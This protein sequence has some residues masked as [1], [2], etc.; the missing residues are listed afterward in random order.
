VK[1]F[2]TSLVALALALSCTGQVGAQSSANVPTM[3]IKIFN[4]DPDHYIY[5]VLTTGKGPVDI[6]LQAF[7]KI[8]ANQ[9]AEHPYKRELVYRIYV[10]PPSGEP[11]LGGGIAP[12][13]SVTLTL[14]L[15]TQLAATVNP[16]EAD[17]YIDWWNGGRIDIFHSGNVPP[18]ALVEDLDLK[19][20]PK[21]KTEVAAV[22]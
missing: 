10:N 12:G 7:F 21:Q 13:Q 5:P 8:P 16:K 19:L 17:Q 18:R 9:T 2:G 22:V 6:W 15:Y 1:T 20:R 3:T 4:D 14:P 11:P